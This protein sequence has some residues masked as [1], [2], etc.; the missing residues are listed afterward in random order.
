MKIESIR[1]K[2]RGFTLIEILVVVAIMGIVLGLAIPNLMRARLRAR[3]QMCIE[4]LSQ[5]ESAK[6]IWGVENSK[7][8]G[9]VPAKSDLIGPGCYMKADPVCP[10]GGTYNLNAIGANASCSLSS[11]GHAL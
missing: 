4:N 3:Q 9:D 10:G 7:K 2:N 11:E 5:I 6:Q 8:D 1:S